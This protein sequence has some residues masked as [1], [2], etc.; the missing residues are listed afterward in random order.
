MGWKGLQWV[1]T[2]D[3][4]FYEVAVCCNGLEGFILGLSELLRVLM[5]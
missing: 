1:K 3:D 5:G 4:G 2:G